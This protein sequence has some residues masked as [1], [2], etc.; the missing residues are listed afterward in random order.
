MA[1]P[2][3]R[4]P[5]EE[6]WCWSLSNYTSLNMS[7]IHAYRSNNIARCSRCWCPVNR[8]VC[9]HL[10]RHG[11]HRSTFTRTEAL[12]LLVMSGQ[13][14]SLLCDRRVKVCYGD[15]GESEP[16]TSSVPRSMNV[17]GFRVR[18]VFLIFCSSRAILALRRPSD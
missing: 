4:V 5:Q 6:T 14:I 9:P 3:P 16:C 8:L 15:Y 17:S 1:E 18:G 12:P 10:R 2:P 11:L 13:T 7:Q